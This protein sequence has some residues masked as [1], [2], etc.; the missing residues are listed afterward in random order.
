MVGLCRCASFFG[1]ILFVGFSDPAYPAPPRGDSCDPR[2]W[3]AKSFVRPS[4]NVLA[5]CLVPSTGHQQ[6]CQTDGNPT[7]TLTHSDP[8]VQRPNPSEAIPKASTAKGRGKC[9][10]DALLNPTKNHCIGAPS[11]EI[12][13]SRP[14]QKNAQG[15][16]PC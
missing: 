6:G 5:P 16:A 9:P 12:N 8:G 7:G 3:Q 4:R 2:A 1:G 15:H 11:T 13:M 10:W 14:L